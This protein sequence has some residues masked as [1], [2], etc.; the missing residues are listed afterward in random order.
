[1]C[2][3]VAA[4]SVS[5]KKSVARRD[6]ALKQEPVIT[7]AGEEIGADVFRMFCANVIEGQDFENMLKTSID[8]GA[9][10]T[11]VKE[12]AVDYIEEYVCLSGEAGKA[13]ISLSAEELN[14]LRH[15]CEQAGGS[16]REKY[17]RENYGI[18]FEDYFKIR[19]GW[20]LA[21][22]YAAKLRM[23]CDISETR[24]AEVYEANYRR[25]AKAEVTMVYFDTSSADEG[26]NG[27]K[28]SNAETVFK[29]IC[30]PSGSETA[31]EGEDAGEENRRIC[32]CRRDGAS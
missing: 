4:V 16:D 30:L 19:S 31:S 8:D 26:A 32:H 15:E 1:M 20:L 3:T 25:F 21:E 10:C 17:Y 9:L 22:K 23:E 18:S 6:A 2:V 13:G 27:F 24:L 7:V 11:A 29:S 5:V 14:N 28:R 12:K